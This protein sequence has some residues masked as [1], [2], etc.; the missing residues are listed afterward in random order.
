MTHHLSSAD[1][2]IFLPETSN[3]RQSRKYWQK[4]HFGTFFLILLTFIESLKVFL[5]D[6]IAILMSAKLATPDILQI[7][8]LLNFMTS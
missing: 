7:T 3:F 2:R 5:I 6:M 4:T 1:I 8:V